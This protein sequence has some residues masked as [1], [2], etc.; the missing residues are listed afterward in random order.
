MP[1]ALGR[2][3][4]RGIGRVI[5]VLFMGRKP[6]AARCLR[7]L[8]ADDRFE[9]VGVLTDHHLDTS[10]TA[11]AAREAGLRLLDFDEAMATI[12]AAELDYDL[13][14][15]MLYWRRLKGCF[16]GHPTRGTINFHPAPLPEYKGVGGYNLAI[17]DGLNRWAASAH[18][19]D[20]GIDTGPIIKKNWF[21]IDP[22][23]ETAQSLEKKSQPELEALFW[24]VMDMVASRPGR[25]PAEPSGPG[26]HLSR[27]ELERMKAVDPDKDDIDRKIRAFWFPPY[28]GAMIEVAGKKY[29]LVNRQILES[30]ADPESSSLF[31]QPA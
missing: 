8:V 5:R 18:F 21:P 2:S 11:D 17:L 3:G 29:T 1:A 28:D 24:E 12:D 4:L 14:I 22:E 6:V 16:L 20:E 19:I 10:P 9:V 31:T 15:S 23:T 27:A 13:G 26:V 30:L 25:V 7:K